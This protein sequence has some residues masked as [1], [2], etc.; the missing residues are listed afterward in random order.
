MHRMH[1][2]G[3]VLLMMKFFTGSMPFL[4]PN[5]QQ[6]SIEELMDISFTGDRMLS[7]PHPATSV[8]TLKAHGK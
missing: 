3:T 5:Q 2:R 8:N 1:N 4:S 7:L 6:Q